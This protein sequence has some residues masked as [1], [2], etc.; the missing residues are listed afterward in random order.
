MDDPGFPHHPPSPAGSLALIGVL[1][2]ALAGLS[3]GHIAAGNNDGGS[4]SYR[5][6]VVFLAAASACFVVALGLFVRE[7]RRAGR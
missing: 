2:L 4:G 1:A 6:V 3:Y 7:R 5:S